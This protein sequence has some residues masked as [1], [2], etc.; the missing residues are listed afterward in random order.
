M[1]VVSMLKVFGCQVV[2]CVVCEELDEFLVSE[3]EFISVWELGVLIIDGFTLVVV[4]GNKVMFK[5]VWL[6][7]ELMMVVDKIIFVVGQYVRL[8]VFV[9]LELQCN[10]IKI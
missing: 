4:E 1:D 7:G 3:K 2:I 10:I 8:D 9:E 6:L 5:Y